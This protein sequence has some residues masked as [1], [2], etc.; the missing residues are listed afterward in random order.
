[1]VEVTKEPEGKNA[2]TYLSS[3]QILWVVSSN[4]N[5]QHE[6]MK[7]YTLILHWHAITMKLNLN[8]EASYNA[9]R[10]T[11]FR[12][13]DCGRT[14]ADLDLVLCGHHQAIPAKP[15]RKD[16]LDRPS[17][18]QH[19]GDPNNPKS[20]TSY[21]ANFKFDAHPKACLLQI[22]EIILHPFVFC[23]TGYCSACTWSLL[24]CDWST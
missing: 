22:P 6:T 19:L 21:F 15:N 7:Y 20:D 8:P 9:T 13:P 4:F 17:V 14:A 16:S 11:P 24:S 5:K 12:R 23:S 3:T 1:M 18:S 2:E 10:F